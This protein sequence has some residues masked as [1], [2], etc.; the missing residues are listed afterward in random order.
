[1]FELSD[2]VQETISRIDNDPYVIGSIVMNKDGNVLKT[3]IDPTLT[4]QVSFRKK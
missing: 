4:S 3:T 1:M 2:E